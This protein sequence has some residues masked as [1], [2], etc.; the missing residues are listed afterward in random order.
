MPLIRSHSQGNGALT[1]HYCDRDGD[2]T[3]RNESNARMRTLIAA[4]SDELP[5]TMVWGLTSHDTLCLMSVPNYDAGP[6]HVAIDAMVGGGFEVTYRPP[7]GDLPIPNSEIVFRVSD[8]DHAIES[9][10]QAMS[11]TRAWRDSPDLTA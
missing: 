8:P 2:M 6:W 4:L 1:D 10:K 5:N 9:I 3:W 7:E 11:L